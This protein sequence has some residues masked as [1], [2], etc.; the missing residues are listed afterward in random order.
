MRCDQH[1]DE[2]CAT[3]VEAVRMLGVKGVWKALFPGF[4]RI[5]ECNE[6]FDVFCFLCGGRRLRVTEWRTRAHRHLLPGITSYCPGDLDLGVRGSSHLHRG[7]A[8]MLAFPTRIPRV[9]K[10]PLVSV[11]TLG[12]FCY[13]PVSILFAC[14]WALHIMHARKK[15][16]TVIL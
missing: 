8:A 15:C 2:V 11:R 13:V 16:E 9:P 7:T 12:Y 5:P 10:Y 14:L 1:C 6:C 4:D 3:P